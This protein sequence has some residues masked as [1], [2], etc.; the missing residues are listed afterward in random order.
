MT[1]DLTLLETVTLLPGSHAS[2][3]D[4][5]CAM[6]AIALA[7]GLPHSDVPA[8]TDAPLA[9]AFQKVNDW[10]GWGSDEARTAFL[11][12]Y[13]M[14]L[15]RLAVA[16]KRAP[17]TAYGFSAADLACRV[18][19]PLSLE[20]GFPDHAAK[21]RGLLPVVDDKTARFAY[22][23]CAAAA[24]LGSITGTPQASSAAAR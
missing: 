1:P 16:G 17:L 2:P 13:L 14:R 8:C 20:A 10:H 24:W 12:P 6:E 19:A 15:G 23:A 11:R 5:V 3:G 9:R 18:F 7:M 22:V 4:G 21:L